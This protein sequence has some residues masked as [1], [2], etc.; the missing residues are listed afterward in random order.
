MRIRQSFLKRFILWCCCAFLLAIGSLPAQSQRLKGH[1]L[2]AL[3]EKF[4]KKGDVVNA[5][6]YYS[7]AAA[8]DPSDQR[9]WAKSLALRTRAA[10]V[11][12]VMM[13]MPPPKYPP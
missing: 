13:P 4:E 10:S 9:Y 7:Q 12:K 11:A 8:A 1:E 5:Y 2:Y 6:L 3:A